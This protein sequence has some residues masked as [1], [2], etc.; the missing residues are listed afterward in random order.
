MNGFKNFNRHKDM[1]EETFNDVFSLLRTVRFDCSFELSNMVY[2]LFDGYLYDELL[3]LSKKELSNDL[4][5][6]VKKIVKD[7]NTYPSLH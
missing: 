3:P 5:N 7:I 1:S 2:G 4:Y 6:V